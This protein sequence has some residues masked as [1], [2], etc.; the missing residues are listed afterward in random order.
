MSDEPIKGLVARVLNTR[1][2]V[3]NKGAAD[4]VYQGMKF[5]VRYHSRRY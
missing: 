5:A 2:L 1:E 4:G 3:I